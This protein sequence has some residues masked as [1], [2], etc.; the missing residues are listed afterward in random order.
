MCMCVCVFEFMYV[1]HMAAHVREGLGMLVKKER[2]RVI[3][4]ARG[5]LPASP[6]SESKARPSSC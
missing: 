3:E 1:M 4:E 5:C 2:F 6:S